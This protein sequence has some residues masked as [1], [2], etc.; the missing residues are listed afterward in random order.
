M[1][2][3]IVQAIGEGAHIPNNSE[4]ERQAEGDLVDTKQIQTDPSQDSCRRSPFQ[5]IYHKFLK[6]LG[7]RWHAPVHKSDYNCIIIVLARIESREK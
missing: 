2:E 3:F 1:R 4:L 5:N 7:G 6:P